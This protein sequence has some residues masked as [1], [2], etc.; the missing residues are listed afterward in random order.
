[1]ATSKELIVRA[2]S[3]ISPALQPSKVATNQGGTVERDVPLFIP[4]DQAYYWS[5]KWQSDEAESLADL[6]AGR[7]RTFDDPASAIRHLLSDD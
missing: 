5:S 4:A 6:A 1:M 7:A 2:G 3:S